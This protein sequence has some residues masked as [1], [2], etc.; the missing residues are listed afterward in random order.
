MVW[1]V[2]LKRPKRVT[3]A[4]A[5]TL[6]VSQPRGVGSPAP[7]CL[8]RLTSPMGCLGASY[9]KGSR[10]SWSCRPVPFDPFSNVR[11]PRA[12]ATI[13]VH[14]NTS[15]SR[16]CTVKQTSPHTI[17]DDARDGRLGV[18][19][20]LPRD[21]ASFPSPLAL[22]S[23]CLAPLH[24]PVLRHRRRRAPGRAPWADLVGRRKATGYWIRNPDGA[25]RAV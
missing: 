16:D 1:T 24:M 6:W 23:A 12:C 18:Q 25:G 20:R 15:S 14:P 17:H 2:A 19:P 7:A 9:I 22:L 8:P 4:L 13:A 21:G 3:I 5:D 11:L 10:Q